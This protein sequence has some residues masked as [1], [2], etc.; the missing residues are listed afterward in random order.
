M[1]FMIQARFLAPWGIKLH[2][3]GKYHT[4]GAIHLIKSRLT[5]N[6]MTLTGLQAGGIILS[7][8]PELSPT[9]YSYNFVTSYKVLPRLTAN[10]RIGTAYR[11]GGFNTNLGDPRQPITIPASPIKT[12]K[13]PHMKLVSEEGYLTE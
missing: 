1:L 5:Q 9:N 6:V 4:K 13:P 2:R 11:S 12:K 8:I 7:S 3:N 10:T